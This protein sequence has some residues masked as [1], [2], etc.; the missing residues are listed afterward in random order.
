M[1]FC[2]AYPLYIR[3]TFPSGRLMIRLATT[4]DA[5]RIAEIQVAAWRAAY[6]GMMPGEYLEGLQVEPR[7]EVWRGTCGREG[8]PLWVR[9]LETEAEMEVAGFCHLMPSRDEDGQ[10]AAEVTSIYLRPDYWRRGLARELLAAAM[11]FAA[12]R[13]FAR[14]TLWVLVENLA[15]RQFYEVLGFRPDGSLKQEQREGFFLNEMRYGWEVGAI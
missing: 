8:A 10:G 11:A 6:G 14:V 12:E 15:A 4:E 2:L 9:M 13:G 5:R 7:E 1:A 3:T